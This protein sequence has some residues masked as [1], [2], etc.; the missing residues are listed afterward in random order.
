M[1]EYPKPQ[2]CENIV[3]DEEIVFC[4]FLVEREVQ[5][6][7]KAVE[8]SSSKSVDVILPKVVGYQILSKRDQSVI[9]KHG[10]N[11]LQL[12]RELIQKSTTPK[13]ASNILQ[14]VFE[15]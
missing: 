2:K 6:G 9:S 10:A 8:M 7:S 13:G 3:I 11:D 14:Y 15:K 1:P 4:L 12:C 5:M